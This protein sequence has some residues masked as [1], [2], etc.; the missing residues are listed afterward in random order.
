MSVMVSMRKIEASHIHSL[1]NK[2]PDFIGGGSGWTDGAYNLGPSKFR[3]GSDVVL[4]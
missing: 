4:V 1:K 3:L 2:P